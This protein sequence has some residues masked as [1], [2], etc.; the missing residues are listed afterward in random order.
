VDSKSKQKQIAGCRGIIPLLGEFEGATPPQGFKGFTPLR[1]HVKE[2]RRSSPHSLLPERRPPQGCGGERGA[3]PPARRV[4]AKIEVRR[5]TPETALETPETASRGSVS[6]RSGIP[7]R[8]R[9]VENAPSR[10]CSAHVS[11]KYARPTAGLRFLLPLRRHGGSKNRHARSCQTARSRFRRFLPD[12]D[13]C[14]ST[15]IGGLRPPFPPTP[16]RRTAL[17]QQGVRGES[18]V[19]CR[20]GPQGCKTFKTLRGRCPLKLPQQGNDSPAPRNLKDRGNDV[21]FLFF[22]A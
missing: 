18:P 16:L 21:W 14:S 3:K 22:V 9:A 20:G 10:G 5:S 17:L 2:H 12:S 13:F 7:A 1:G 4:G 19:L 8:H 6:R 11:G 15:S